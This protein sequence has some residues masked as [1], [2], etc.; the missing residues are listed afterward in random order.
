MKRVIR[1]IIYLFSLI[2]LLLL[3]ACEHEVLIS[4]GGEEI[5][6]EEKV[7]IELLDRKS[8]V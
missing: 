4:E 2:V 6:P 3:S 5:V 7:Q 8:V 1:H